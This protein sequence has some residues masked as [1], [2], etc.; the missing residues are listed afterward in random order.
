MYVRVPI[1]LMAFVAVLGADVRDEQDCEMCGLLVW[2]LE[3]M[4]AEKM[5]ETESLKERLEA[6]AKKRGVLG[7]TMRSE[8]PAELIDGMESYLEK[9]CKNDVMLTST[10]CRGHNGNDAS[11]LR[12]PGGG[13]FLQ[14]ACKHLVQERCQYVVDEHAEEL[15]EAAMFDLTARQCPDILATGCSASRATTILGPLYG[16]AGSHGQHL[17]VG[18]K[19]VWEKSARATRS[20]HPPLS[21]P[22]QPS[23]WIA[24]GVACHRK[25][26]HQ[27]SC[28][29]GRDRSARVGAILSQRSTAHFAA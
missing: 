18:V 13:V 10:A 19:D 16:T 15:I 7:R 29:Y 8:Y 6:A 24:S 17:S 5:R 21:L 14:E 11:Q 22:P 20:P 27:H 25:C 4:R 3:T 23:L 28:V 2:R 1:V 12:N 9:A 26:A